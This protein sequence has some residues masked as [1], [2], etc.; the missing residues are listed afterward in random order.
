MPQPTSCCRAQQCYCHRC[1]VL[2]GL[3]GLHVTGVVRFDAG[4]VVSVETPPQR[5]FCPVCGTV[6]VSRGRRE[7][8]LVDVPA[9][10]RPVRL[11]WR[12]RTWRCVQPDCPGATFT[13]QNP[14]VARPRALLS[15]RACWWAVRQIRYEHASVRGLARQLGCTWN[16]VWDSIRPLL[17]ERAADESR[18]DDVTELGVDEHI[19]HHTDPRRRGPKAMTGMVDLGRDRH[20]RVRARLLDLVPGRS[21][22][23]YA[24]WLTA[25]G[26]AFCSRVRI[27][28]LDPF[29]GYKNAIDDRLDDAVA[30]LDAFHVVKLGTAAVDEVRRRV[31]QAIHGHRGRKGDPLYRI[32]TILRAGA[33]NLTDRQWDRLSTAFGA[34]SR[35]D[36]VFLAW[37]CAQQLRRAYH[38]PNLADGRRLAEQVIASFPSCPVPEI[39]RLGRTLR[40]WKNEFL[41]YFTTNRTSNGGTEA[42]NG[43]IELHRRIARGFRNRTNYRLRMLLIG[44]GLDP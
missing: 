9:F 31:Q 8:R 34:D 1:D 19:W 23:V 13:E 24:D 10:G 12:K 11:V 30:V 21:G 44:G 5:G 14:E 36:E 18:F 25:R 26:N 41:A 40:Q 20:G 43:L 2:V 27:A 32:R 6:A 3:D 38:E 4:L 35:H 29:R 39:A 33:E 17:E 22:T 15:R 42:I 28:A 16:T 37:Q 7:H